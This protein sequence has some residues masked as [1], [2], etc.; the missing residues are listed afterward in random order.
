[1]TLQE[2]ITHIETQI[3]L[4]KESMHSIMR[5]SDVILPEELIGQ[6]LDDW[7]EARRMVVVLKEHLMR[8]ESITNTAIHF[9]FINLS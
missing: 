2:Q 4:L 8:V 5:N 3:N 6:N 1:M 7:N 9:I